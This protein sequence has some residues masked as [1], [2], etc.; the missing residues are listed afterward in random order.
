MLSVVLVPVIKD[1]AGK[2]CSKDN[3]HPIALASV[4]S[5]IIEV[6]ILGRI[7]IFLDTNPN[8]FGFKKKHGT[9]QCIYVL[10]EIIDLY[11]TL[12]GSVFVCFLDAS[13]AF[14]RV[15][16][17]HFHFTLLSLKRICILQLMITSKI[18]GMVSTK[19]Q[20]NFQMYTLQEQFNRVT[21]IRLI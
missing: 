18:Y 20:I 10:K 16:H 2:I 13:K 14:D 11:Q 6:I 15:N 7:E 19:M 3:Y 8:Q 21:S 12:N 1:I 4:F 5:K 17:F 9:D